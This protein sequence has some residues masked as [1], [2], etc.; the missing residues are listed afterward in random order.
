MELF[1][2]SF[3]DSPELLT[4]PLNVWSAFYFGIGIVLGLIFSGLFSSAEVAFFSLSGQQAAF[5]EAL[6]SDPNLGLVDR[7][8]AKPRR[9]LA[10]ILMGNTV[11]NVIVSVLAAVLTGRLM[12]GFSA[13]EWLIFLIEVV[14]VTFLILILSEITPKYVAINDPIKASSKLSRVLFFFY[15]ILGPIAQFIGTNTRRLEAYLPKPNSRLTSEDIKAM[16]EVGDRHGT[17]VDDER[18]IIENVIEF[19]NTSTKE[20]MTS[21]VNMKAIS[22]DMNLQQVLDFIKT[23]GLSRMPLYENDLDNIKGVIHSK[24]LLPF[25]EHPT[26]E[27]V[28]VNWSAIARPAMFVPLSKKIDDLLE[29]FQRLRTHLAIVVDEYGGTEGLVTLDDVLEEIVGDL[30]DE[31]DEEETLYVPLKN[32]AFLFDAKIDLDDV[33][34]ILGS[35]ITDDDDE[36]ETLGGLVYHL[37]ERIPDQGE[38]ISFKNM[39]LTVQEVQKNRVSKVRIK[40]LPT[41]DKLTEK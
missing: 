22:T 31:Y 25:L 10:T 23:N 5:N 3:I 38:K 40:V 36:F 18:E 14:V 34:D 29:D 7:M 32:G 33:S 37:F 24:D 21:R 35:E 17:L 2:S 26:H 30:A 4:E 1:I 6:K 20:I 12:G 19:S 41:E 16:A 27:N 11:A 39:E 28:A 8:L 13:P 9:L 15:I